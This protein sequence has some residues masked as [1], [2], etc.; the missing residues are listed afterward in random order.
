MSAGS[1]AT[2]KDKKVQ[3]P[4]SDDDL[5]PD[6]ES[7][8]RKQ[9]LEYVKNS[10]K[11]KEQLAKAA[12]DKNAGSERGTG[13]DVSGMGKRSRGLSISNLFDADYLRDQDHHLLQSAAERLKEKN[14]NSSADADNRIPGVGRIDDL[15]RDP[16]LVDAADELLRDAGRRAPWLQTPAERGARRVRHPVDD[17]RDLDDSR[18]RSFRRDR[19]DGGGDWSSRDAVLLNRN[20]GNV[21]NF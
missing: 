1:G 5:E 15:R 13:F 9:L 21:T 11:T 8:T 2:R 7:M 4:S 20:R 10:N 6:V 12:K 16:R 18:D 19:G 14:R 3:L 17:R